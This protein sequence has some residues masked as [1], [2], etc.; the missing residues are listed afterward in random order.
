MSERVQ[1][2]SVFYIT[3]QGTSMH[4]GVQAG[5]ELVVRPLAARE[6]EI[7]DILL[8]RREGS[9]EL[10]AHRLIQRA[11]FP[12][13]ARPLG[14]VGDRDPFHAEWIAESQVVGRIELLKRRGQVLSRVDLKKQY[15]TFLIFR[16][17][18]R[19]I[20]KQL[21]S[22]AAPL[23]IM[24]LFWG[25]RAVHLW[26]LHPAYYFV[27]PEDLYRGTI[28]REWLRGLRFPLIDYRAD[29][30]SGGSLAVGLLTSFFFRLMGSTAL[31]LK[32]TPLVLFSA[33]L[34]FWCLALERHGGKRA[35]W[36]FALLYIFSPPSFTLFSMTSMGFHSESVVFTALTLFLT[37][38]ILENNSH[39]VIYSG[40]L[41]LVAG[42]GL[43]FSYAYAVTLATLV[44]FLLLFRRSFQRASA[45]L[46]AAGFL[47]GF[48]PWIQA[49]LWG[50]VNGLCIGDVPVWRIFSIR[51]LARGVRHEPFFFASSIA[52]MFA[53]ES[54]NPTRILRLN[55]AYAALGGALVFGAFISKIRRGPL[56][57]LEEWPGLSLF[58][59][60]YVVLF[61]LALETCRLGE[62][63][64]RIPLFPF[65]FA[66]AA[67]AVQELE[68]AGRAARFF[69]RTLL[70]LLIGLGA[71]S[72]VT[73]F[74]RTWAGQMASFKGY[75]YRFIPAAFQSRGA[76]LIYEHRI[77]PGLEKTD[78]EELT[79]Q[80]AMLRAVD[81]R[82][83]EGFRELEA[84]NKNESPLFQRLACFLYPAG[85]LE[86]DG[87]VPAHAFELVRRL[88][89][90]EAALGSM[91]LAYA[92][93]KETGTPQRTLREVAWM[94]AAAPIEVRRYYDRA[95]GYSWARTQIN[96]DWNREAFRSRLASRLDQEPREIRPEFIQGV[97]EY[98]F[99]LWN[100]SPLDV[101]F[102]PA[103]LE[104]FPPPWQ[105]DLFLGAGAAFGEN[106]DEITLNA[107]ERRWRY[108]AFLQD[109]TEASRESF[110]QGASEIVRALNL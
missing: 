85:I 45:L 89:P 48:W 86:R 90:G 80:T 68:S 81:L 20:K 14:M 82:A 103:E 104:K 100:R 28:G 2:T 83:G 34:A 62:L 106:L 8:F 108:A 109:L 6:I 23:F 55:G 98:L 95:E 37:L 76:C 56:K 70:V 39:P 18:P 66:G 31:A 91:G 13:G 21:A 54:W 50:H 9:E 53:P 41:G 46:F 105:D 64:Y 22:K 65:L 72:S 43:W 27:T 69:A 74:S 47:I 92:L 101:P 78:A 25:W 59:T 75:S 96:G 67:L 30:Y 1:E 10:V 63:R 51:L 94:R 5:D 88:S 97:G 107:F 38:E 57:P 87:F 58:L 40:L 61:A 17:L 7:G 93:A 11:P 19:W 60:G 35:A 3:A 84:M 32:M 49:N 15:R 79:A 16:Y 71:C 52:G 99:E 44:L 29:D 24:A 73:L 26:R 102:P 110:A 4:P 42:A 77:L 33:A 36:A 12:E